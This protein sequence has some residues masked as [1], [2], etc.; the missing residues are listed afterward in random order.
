VEI[1]ITNPGS[2][3]VH[4]SQWSAF[5][6]RFGPFDHCLDKSVNSL[7]MQ[8]SPPLPY[9]WFHGN[10]DRKAATQIMTQDEASMGTKRESGHFLV[11]FSD[12]Y[13]TDFV[14]SY[15]KV[16]DEKLCY[17]SVVIKNSPSG[18]FMQ[19][20]K[21]GAQEYFPTVH[22][23]IESERKKNRLNHSIVSKMYRSLIELQKRKSAPS[24]YHRW[25][26][27]AEL[28][29]EPVKTTGDPTNNSVYS[30]WNAKALPL[31]STPTPSTTSSTGSGGYMIISDQPKPTL[32]PRT[33]QTQTTT[34]TTADTSSPYATWQ[35]G[36]KSKTK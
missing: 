22:A 36:D 14:L 1:A 32:S 34:T 12:K 29:E 7:F 35:E 31:D 9:R 5:L 16:K 13:P 25:N 19:T 26:P 2:T 21:R 6:G 27:S 17:K 20:E 8:L 3:K 28:P 33:T 15:S 18:Y 11:R 30:T 24:T 10:Q 23:L 4:V